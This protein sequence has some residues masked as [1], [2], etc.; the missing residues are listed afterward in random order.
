M[1]SFCPSCLGRQDFGL[2]C[3]DCCAAVEAMFAAAPQ[4]IEQLDVAASK[5]AKLTSAS[6][7]GKGSAHEKSPVN[8]GAVAARDA[9][10]VEIAL[11][12]D[13]IDGLRHHPKAA[14]IVSGI[15]R[16][17]KDAYSAID[18]MRD[19][20]YLG[21][22]N[23]QKTCAAELWAKPNASQAKCSECGYVHDIAQRQADLMDV[24]ED[25]IVTPLEASRYIGEFGEM[26]IGHQRIRNYLDR[27]RITERPSPDGVKRF[28]LGDLLELLRADATRREKR[29]V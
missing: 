7:A 9:L 22:C 15:G 2:L 1:T 27:K 26:Q 10:L 25:L 8:W 4:L 3:A 11:W 16:A 23:Y 29:A 17:V 24:A 28:R 5:Q 6:K 19:R 14:E 13:D 20:K 21:R 18:R 12:A